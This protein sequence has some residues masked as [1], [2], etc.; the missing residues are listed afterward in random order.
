MSETLNIGTIKNISEM[1]EVLFIPAFILALIAELSGWLL[2][3]THFSHF[4]IYFSCALWGAI[5]SGLILGSIGYINATICP[6]ENLGAILGV[7]M[8]P[9]GLLTVF[10]GVLPT[11]DLGLSYASGFALIT[12]SFLLLNTNEEA[13]G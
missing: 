9:L 1:S 11:F 5:G 3:N 8:M 12:W 13:K 7:L 4:E 6:E 2:V 10:N